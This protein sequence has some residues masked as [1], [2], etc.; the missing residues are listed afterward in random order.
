MMPQFI[1]AIALLAGSAALFGTGYYLGEHVTQGAVDAQ[2][3]EDITALHDRVAEQQ[4]FISET[5]SAFLDSNSKIKTVYRDR[6]R[7]IEKKGA[8]HVKISDNGT[9]GVDD[10]GVQLLNQALRGSVESTDPTELIKK[11]R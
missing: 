1:I 6:V 2:A 7:Y 3:L 5:E 4:A 11:L 10:G 9:C 8:D